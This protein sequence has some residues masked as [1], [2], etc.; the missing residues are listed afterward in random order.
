MAGS[1]RLNRTEPHPDLKERAA[2][3]QKFPAQAISATHMLV[4]ERFSNSAATSPARGG[5][6]WLLGRS[7]E[8][9]S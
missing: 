1:G 4:P 7:D 9:I 8:P 5:T 2:R 6:S 3:R